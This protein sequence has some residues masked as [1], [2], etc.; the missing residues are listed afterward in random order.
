MAAKHAGLQAKCF[1]RFASNSFR[2]KRLKNTR[3]VFFN[4]L[5]KQA[6]LPR[7]PENYPIWGIF[8]C[9]FLSITGRVKQATGAIL[10]N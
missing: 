4:T 7:E 9:F 6:A 10:L 1:G 8:A 5:L 2:V 3:T